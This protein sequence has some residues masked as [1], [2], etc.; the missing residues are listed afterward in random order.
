MPYLNK[1]M[2][3][4]NFCPS[5]VGWEAYVEGN[6]WVREM[7]AETLCHFQSERPALGKWAKMSW[8]GI[9]RGKS[10]GEVKTS[11]CQVTLHYK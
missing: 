2:F 6:W 5:N 4:A 3:Y 8:R 7:A 9:Y 11:S 1:C 10:G